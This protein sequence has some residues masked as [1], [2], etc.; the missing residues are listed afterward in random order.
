MGK[1][2]WKAQEEQLLSWRCIYIDRY[3]YIYRYIIK[4]SI[5]IYI[6]LV[7]IYPHHLPIFP[8]SPSQAAEVMEKSTAVT[9]AS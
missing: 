1:E 8:S 3:L 5:Y 7:I 9:V 2:C 6:S 4:K